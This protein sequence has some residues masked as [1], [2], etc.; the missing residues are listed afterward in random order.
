[1]YLSQTHIPDEGIQFRN[2]SVWKNMLIGFSG[3]FFGCIYIYIY[4]MKNRDITIQIN[5]PTNY[6]IDVS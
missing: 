6:Y 1:M 3:W 5:G 2:I 4:S